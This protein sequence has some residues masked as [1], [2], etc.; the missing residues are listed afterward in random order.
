VLTCINK[1]LRIQIHYYILICY[2]IIILLRTCYIQLLYC[3][4]SY[5]DVTTRQLVAMTTHIV[6]YSDVSI[7]SLKTDSNC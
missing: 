3:V 4:E 7:L 2:T 1:L 5:L 6:E